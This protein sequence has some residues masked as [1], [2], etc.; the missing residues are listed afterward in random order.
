MH[1]Y[2]YKFIHKYKYKHRKMQHSMITEEESCQSVPEAEEV[3][4][5]EGRDLV[6]DKVNLVYFFHFN[7]SL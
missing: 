3:A 2:K 4:V 6:P 7:I 1:K 5:R